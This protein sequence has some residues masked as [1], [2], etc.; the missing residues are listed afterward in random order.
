MIGVHSLGE[1]K[2]CLKYYNASKD[3]KDYTVIAKSTKY[4][5]SG[6]CMYCNHYLSCPENIYIATVNKFLDLATIGENVP[7]TIREHYKSLN[8][9]ASDCIQCGACEKN[10]PFDVDIRKRMRKA[11]EVFASQ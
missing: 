4:A 3:E 10:C 1:L 5:M 8:K 7:D 2:E 9:N 11:I 6:K